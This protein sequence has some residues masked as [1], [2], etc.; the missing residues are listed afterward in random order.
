MIIMFKLLYQPMWLFETAC[1]VRTWPQS[2][3]LYK[4]LILIH[5]YIMYLYD[6]LL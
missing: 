1:N 4:L 2:Y 5:E 3:I 6:K